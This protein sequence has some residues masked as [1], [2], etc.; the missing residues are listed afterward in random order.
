M[1]QAKREPVDEDAISKRAGNTALLIYNALRQDILAGTRSS[2]ALLPQLTIA[3]QFGTSRAPVREAL[4]RLEQEQLIVARANQRYM[5][6]QFDVTDYEDLLS[7]TL[8]NMTF[9]IRLSVPS[10]TEQQLNQVSECVASMNPLIEQDAEGRGAF[11]R[12]FT[13]LLIAPA[14]K[15]TVALISHFMD[16]LQRYRAHAVSKL[17]EALFNDGAELLELVKAARMG[18]AELAAR[19]YSKY[20][21]RLAILI[22]AAAA[23][24]HDPVALRAAITTLMSDDGMSRHATPAAAR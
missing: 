1:D 12:N 21:S 10:L 4:Q 6:A 17:P 24:R 13:S 3:K 22:L 15:R 2:G 19:L 7:L 16:N 14:G 9:A 18:D 5:V 20:F 8:I 23:P 11:Y